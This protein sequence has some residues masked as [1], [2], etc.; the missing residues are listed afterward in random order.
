MRVTL[1]TSKRGTNDSAE[2][3]ELFKPFGEVSQVSILSMNQSATNMVVDVM[4]IMNRDSRSFGNVDLFREIL[5]R[6]FLFLTFS[7]VD[8]FW[9][10][11]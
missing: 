2:L 9:M 6:N 11:C 1:L 3:L 7:H 10:R 8:C 5:S 4:T